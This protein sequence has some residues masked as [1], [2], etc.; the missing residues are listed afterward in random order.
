MYSNLKSV[1]YVVAMLKAKGI[2]KCVVSPGNSH[3]ALVRSIEEDNYFKT[4][5]IVDERS[6][7]FFAIG[8]I[9]ELKEP[10]AIM[11]TAGT[12][13]SNYLS[14]VTEAFY[15][16]LPLVVIT[17]DKNPYYINQYEDQTIIQNDIFKN[18]VKYH[19]S[20]PIAKDQ[21]D[22]WYINR[23]LNEAFL[24]MTHHG[25]GPIH[26]NVPIDEGKLAIGKSFT[27]KYLPSINIINRLD[28][29]STVQEWKAKVKSLINKKVLFIYGQDDHISEEVR[30]NILKISKKINCVFATDNISNLHGKGVVKIAKASLINKNAQNKELYP[31]IVISL[32]G[33]TVLDFKFQLKR[34]NHSFEHWIVNE[35]G[36][37]A[38]PFMKLTTVFEMSTLNFLKDLDMYLEGIECNNYYLS[39]W[40]TENKKFV[41]PEFEFSNL[42]TLD[43]FIKLIPPNSILN[44]GNSSTIRLTQYFELDETIQV[45]AN[46]GVNGIDGCVSTYIGQSAVTEKLS[47]LIVGDLTYFYD[48]NAIW[49]RYVGNNVRILLNNNSGA[50]LF[51]FNQGLDNY[52]SLNENVAA[53]HTT[54]T[55]GWAKDQGFK[56]LS[57]STKDEFDLALKEFIV[58][59]SS[60][61]IIFEVFTEKEKDAKIQHEF[62]RMNKAPLEGTQVIK[63]GVKK[64]IKSIIGQDA[65]NKLRN[66]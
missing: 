38:D 1:Q 5:N 28:R 11:C 9:Q 62:Y 46:R 65:I 21:K 32:A 19:V 51:H 64:T 10:I 37:V 42:Y 55:K 7:A 50:A 4:Y 63:A 12:A 43:R 34:L 45:Y 33:N 6:A 44:L 24:E 47:F 57:A 27:E 48:M 22:E 40:E 18:V 16:K 14:G 20:L 39:A 29:Q 25:N 61:P 49:N 58:K 3:N 2:N 41:V 23:V 26:I 54:T 36:K 35:N 60:Q 66:K 53:E 59:D 17:A 52:P 15:R 31:D 13:V 56:Y 8:L 30:A